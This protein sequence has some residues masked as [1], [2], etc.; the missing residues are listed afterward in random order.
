LYLSVLNRSSWHHFGRRLATL[1]VMLHKPHSRGRVRLDHGSPQA[2]P[3]A[4][5]AFF[6]DPRDLDRMT[7]AVRRAAEML[8]DARVRALGRQCGLVIPSQAANLLASRT[9]LTRLSNAVASAMM[10]LLPP[11]EKRLIAP[12]LSEWPLDKVRTA[13]HDQLRA[14]LARV[15]T[16]VFHPVGTC[17]MG[18]AGDAAAVVD[19]TGRVHG[20]QGLRVADASVMPEI[21][22]AGTFLPT[23]MVAEKIADAIRRRA[24]A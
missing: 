2:V 1:N 6:S 19:T 14:L 7:T 5:F 24:G 8:S 9:P 4:D 22:R 3:Q 21:P 11:L 13:G 23:V 20:I 10:R 15:V 17:R 16:G 12:L 18:A